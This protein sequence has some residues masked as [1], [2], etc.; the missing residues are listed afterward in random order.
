[1]KQEKQQQK[2][3]T[4]PVP[5]IRDFFANRLEVGDTVI[6]ARRT[7]DPES[8]SSG[9]CVVIVT[10]LIGAMTPDQES[11]ITPPNIIKVQS[12]VPSTDDKG[13][14]YYATSLLNAAL[15]AKFEM[16]ES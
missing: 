9:L 6:V 13:N 10:E 11:L 1:M 5:V 15:V 3:T 14:H 8:E 16:E 12:R 7:V 4:K 2:E